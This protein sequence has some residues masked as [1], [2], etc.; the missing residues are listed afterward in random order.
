MQQ[1]KRNKL[2]GYKAVVTKKINS[3]EI[4]EAEKQ[5]KNTRI[6]N[7]RDALN[8]YINYHRNKLKTMKGS[9][10]RRK[11]RGGNVMFFNNPKELLKKCN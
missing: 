4:S 7:I 3:G 2:N 5:L 9:G 11:Q 10:I 6:E 1:K 8:E